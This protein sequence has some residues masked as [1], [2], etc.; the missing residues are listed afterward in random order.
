MAEG[1]SFRRDERP[2]PRSASGLIALLI[3]STLL[4]AAAAWL[5]SASGPRGTLVT[6][7]GDVPSPGTYLLDDPTVYRAVAAAGRLDPP[8]T[9]DGPVPDGHRVEVHGP[10]ATVRPPEDAL[11]VGLPV[12]VNEAT[13]SQLM[14]I[15]GVGPSLAG[16]ILADRLERGPF[17]HLGDLDRVDGIG[18]ATLEALAPF[19][20]LPAAPPESPKGPLDINRASAAD[21]ESLPGIGAVTAARIVVDREENGPFPT[22]RALGRVRGVGPSTLDALEGL[23]EARP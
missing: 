7:V 5:G 21:L 2:P 6:V 12:D 18:P 19:V 4:A 17:M 16:A 11:L 22:L 8:T 1:L 15:P 3:V 10:V 20:D 13:L 9:P 14:A 23:A